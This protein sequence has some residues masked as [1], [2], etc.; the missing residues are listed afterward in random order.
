M[1]QINVT[2]TTTG[3][4]T[5]TTDTVNGVWFNAS[6]NF[7]ATGPATLSLTG[8]G[9]PVNS[10]PFTY[11]VKWG[12]STCT[13]SCTFNPAPVIDYFPRTT[14]SNWS[15]EFNDDPLDSLY[16][17]VIAATLAAPGGT[18]NIFMADDGTGLDSSGY[19][20]R[21]GGDYFEWIDLSTIIFDNPTWFQYIML[22]DNVAAGSPAWKSS[23]ASGTVLSTPVTVRFSYQVIQK[24]VP[25]SVTTSL[26][27]QNYTNVIV[28]EE[29]YEVEVSPG[30]WQDMTAVWGYGRSYYA[31]NIGLIQYLAFD[32]TNNEQFRM[33]LRRHQVF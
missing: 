2:V 15:Y 19:Y 29:K 5:I 16:R 31:R 24:D 6:G 1:V 23:A 9:T 13:F 20:R 25:I 3:P 22:K 14:N 32:G 4:Y 28:V 27:T 33:E 30:V 26:G 7:T 21:S 18:Y 10:G 11:T 12:T 17:T 8:N